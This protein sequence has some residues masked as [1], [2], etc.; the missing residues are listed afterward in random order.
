LDHLKRKNEN[1]G[2]NTMKKYSLY[3]IAVPLT[4]I[5]AGLLL[6]FFQEEPIKIE[7]DNQW[8]EEYLKKAIQE[9]ENK[10]T[11]KQ[12][13]IKLT[14][15]EQ[16]VNNVDENKDYS[17]LELYKDS[18]N[19]PR[20]VG[21]PII[22]DIDGDGLIEK[23]VR[24]DLQMA[25]RF[26][27]V[28]YIY[29]EINGEYKLIKTFYGDPYGFAKMI[30]EDTI[31]VGRFLPI[32]YG[33]DFSKNWD[34]FEQFEIIDYKWTRDGGVETNKNI[35]Q[36][37][38]HTDLSE[39]IKNNFY[40]DFSNTTYKQVVDS[41]IEPPLS[42]DFYDT[43]FNGNIIEWKAKIS[44]YYSQITGIKFCVVDED[45]QNINIDEPCDWFWAS[46]GGV[47]DA[48]NLKK[49]PSWDGDWVPY[50]LNYYKV[51]FNENGR[52]YNE[53]YTIKGI[54]DGLNCGFGDKCLP[55]IQILSITK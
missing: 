45:H 23:V 47:M 42:T 9:Q 15:K 48:D 3:I 27:Q 26:I 13:E 2:K 28:L 18:G 36:V 33:V 10:T 32:Q 39:E 14:S 24:Y 37:S 50:I 17:N 46:S 22:K 4:I 20:I 52:Y 51:P 31:I 1:L 53:V 54:V 8:I 49:N 29:R 16:E 30:N 43:K 25:N 55:L 44:A 40:G 35:I 41:K 38:S 11:T 21:E 19:N 7:A 34:D 6:W 12:D 5:V